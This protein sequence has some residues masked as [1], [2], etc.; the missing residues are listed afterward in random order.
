MKRAGLDTPA[1]VI[2]N[3]RHKGL[4]RKSDMVCVC[5][6][7]CVRVCVCVHVCCVCVCKPLLWSPYSSWISSGSTRLILLPANDA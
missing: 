7:V 3:T 1:M 6:C 2:T 4:D 5:V